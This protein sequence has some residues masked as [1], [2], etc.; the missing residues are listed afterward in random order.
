MERKHHRSTKQIGF[1]G[2]VFWGM[3]L[4]LAAGGLS[5][6][7][8]AAILSGAD[9]PTAHLSVFGLAGAAISALVTGYAARKL[10]GHPTPIPSLIGGAIL[11]VLLAAGGLCFPGS[12]LPA[13]VRCAGIPVI[14]LLAVL[15]S[16]AVPD[17]KRR[18]HT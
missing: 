17:G 8:F 4:G 2:A 14:V 12:T 13:A 18:R 11:A 3:G 6:L 9:D 10:W 15:A 1:W 5:L 16:L 7:L